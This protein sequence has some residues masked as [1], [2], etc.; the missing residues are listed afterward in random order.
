MLL[1]H[2]LRRRRKLR[3]V[4]HEH[5]RFFSNG[6]AVAKNWAPLF[7]FVAGTNTKPYQ[8]SSLSLRTLALLR[9]AGAIPKGSPLKAEHIRHTAL[10]LV[11]AF[12]PEKFEETTANAR[13]TVETATNTC[14]LRVDKRSREHIAAA[15]N[16]DKVPTTA[17]DLLTC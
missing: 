6:A 1:H 12:L 10:T 17:V 4:A 15:F 7:V 9:E 2:F 13:H 8:R 16:S 3:Q 11:H 5:L 14:I